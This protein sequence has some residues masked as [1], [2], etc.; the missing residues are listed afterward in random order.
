MNDQDITHFGYKK[1]ATVEK[2]RKV[3]DVFDSVA[4]KYDLMNDLMSFGIHR[5]WKRF[6]IGLCQLRPGQ[7][8][9]DLAG[10][11]GDL[12]AKISAIVSRNGRVILADINHMMLKVGQDRL[13]DRGILNHIDIVQTDAECLAFPDNYFDRII[14]GFGLRKCNAASQCLSLYVS[15]FTTGRITDYFRI[16]KT[17]ISTLIEDLRYLFF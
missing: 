15:L 7:R 2:S 4:A 6:A 12:A 5:L 1:V 17:H 3:A 9:L 11:T 8:V 10:G 14:I 16:F 13:L